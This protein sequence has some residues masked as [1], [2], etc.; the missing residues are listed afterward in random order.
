MAENTLHDYQVRIFIK[1]Q[2]PQVANV[3]ARS[4]EEAMDK[5]V[6]IYHDFAKSPEGPN[7]TY[8]A[9]V[10]ALSSESIQKTY[11]GVLA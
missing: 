1:N 3:K 7:G 2:K 4:T 9:E 11:V 6:H 10:V 8:M 5:A